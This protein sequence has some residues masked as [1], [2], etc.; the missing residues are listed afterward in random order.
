MELQSPFR[1][2]EQ[3]VHCTRGNLQ[4]IARRQSVRR[5]CPLDVI[6]LAA[7]TAGILLRLTIILLICLIVGV[8]MVTS[9]LSF[10]FLL[11][12]SYPY[13]PC[14]NYYYSEDASHY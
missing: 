7:V 4:K 2:A 13:S 5:A 9:I 8:I 11:L 3:A 12:Y 14:S 1:V 6:I 10:V